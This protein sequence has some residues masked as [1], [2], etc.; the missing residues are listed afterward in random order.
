[1]TDGA[2]SYIAHASHPTL[3]DQAADGRILIDQWHFHFHSDTAE[4][5]IPLARLE[6]ALGDA[7]TGGIFFSDPEQPDW[8]VYTYDKR[9]L[10]DIYLTRNANTRVQLKSFQSR[11]ELKTRVKITIWVLG[12]FFALAAAVTIFT[13]IAVRVLV[14]KIP[15]RFE[16]DLGASW[17]AE[18]KQ[19]ETFIT[20]TNLQARVDQAAAP[21]LAVLPTNRINFQ[22]FIIDDPEPNAFSIPG[23]YVMFTTGLLQRMDKPEQIAGVMAHEMAHITEK[24]VF[25]QVISSFGPVLLIE[26]LFQNSNNR[27]NAV[28]AASSLLI[29]QS[30]SQEYEME[31]DA[32]GWEYLLKARINPHGMIEMLSKLKAYE[33]SQKDLDFLPGALRSHPATA[34][35][36][37]KL[38]SKWKRVKEKDRLHFVEFDLEKKP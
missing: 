36:I 7:E 14:S 29:V 15:P 26:L 12:G 21:L 20:D 16:Q 4:V 9:I 3:G 35:R 38:E 30:F 24:H 37:R 25:R 33:D 1:M 28:S 5:Q 34:K 32:V 18:V 10:Q 22:F 13:G 31:A 2:S 8:S 19:E 23:G 27:F 6:I 11:G 17:L